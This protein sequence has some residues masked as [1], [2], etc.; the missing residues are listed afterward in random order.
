MT[1]PPFPELPTPRDSD[2]AFRAGVRGAPCVVID[3]LPVVPVLVSYLPGPCVSAVERLSKW[4]PAQN[5][6]SIDEHYKIGRALR[7]I[8]LKLDAWR[9][10]AQ[11]FVQTGQMLLDHGA[12]H[13]RL[14]QPYDLN[15]LLEDYGKILAPIPDR[16]RRG[17]AVS[18]ILDEIH[19]Y[20]KK[21]RQWDQPDF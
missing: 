2:Q 8:A 6:P 3:N 9:E 15:V 5:T 1:L 19:A 21:R 16:A 11:T 7:G 4:P 20:S 12:L 17:Q 14:S 10:D 18:E 13:L